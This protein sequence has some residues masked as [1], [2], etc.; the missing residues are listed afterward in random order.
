MKKKIFSSKA[1]NL[2]NLDLKKTKI[3]KSVFFSVKEFK[4]NQHKI[5]KNI[6]KNFKN[7]IIVRSSNNFEDS[8]KFSLAGNFE[9]VS[10]V[11]PNDKI[12]LNNSIL[13]VIKS[14]KKFYSAKNE[15]LVQDFITDIRMSGVATSCDLKKKL[16]IYYNQFF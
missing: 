9:S 1:R 3:P 15:V 12:Q 2:L 11:D 7:K 10:G 16:T 13:K 4:K 8:R 14:Y 5:I 6:Q